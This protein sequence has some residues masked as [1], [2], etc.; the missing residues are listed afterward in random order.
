MLQYWMNMSLLAVEAQEVIWLRMFKL[1]AGGPSAQREAQRMIA[2]KFTA[3]TEASGQL[4]MGASPES[5]ID[6]Y[7]KKIRS[8]TRRLRK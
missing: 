8:N 4:M 3:A 1:A 5:V 7:R 2:E 6:G